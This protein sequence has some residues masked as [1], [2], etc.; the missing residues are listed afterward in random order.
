MPAGIT[1]VEIL[2]AG[3][4]FQQQVSV[5]VE[6]IAGCGELL[7]PRVD[8][9]G[10]RFQ[11]ELLVREPVFVQCLRPIEFRETIP[12]GTLRPGFYQVRIN[13]E[14]RRFRV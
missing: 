4:G 12:L 5:I 14:I 6:G 2:V 10:R 13:D 8:Q 7:P 11:I 1:N 9:R 3:N